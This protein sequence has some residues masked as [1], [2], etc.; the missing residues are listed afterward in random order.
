MGKAILI[1]TVDAHGT[2]PS[3]PTARWSPSRLTRGIEFDPG[4]PAAEVLAAWQA[5]L[6]ALRS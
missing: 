6:D 4:R 2:R 5:A 1:A 3:S